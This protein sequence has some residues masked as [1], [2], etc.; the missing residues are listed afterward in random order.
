MINPHDWL[1][2][3]GVEEIGEEKWGIEI[4]ALNN[5]DSRWDIASLFSKSSKRYA[6]FWK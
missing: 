2:E 6:R 1:D 4:K 3:L 5:P